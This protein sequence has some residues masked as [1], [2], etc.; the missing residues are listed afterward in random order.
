[1]HAAWIGAMAMEGMRLMSR[2]LQESSG[3]RGWWRAIAI[4]LLEW[5]CFTLQGRC[6]WKLQA[7]CRVG[8]RFPV[9]AHSRGSGDGDAGAHS[10]GRVAEW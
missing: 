1:M 4:W 7:A 10:G 3:S 5:K 8:R 9:V 6:R 2:E